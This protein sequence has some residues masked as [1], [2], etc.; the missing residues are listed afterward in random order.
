MIV[1]CILMKISS[2]FVSKSTVSQPE[3]CP[4]PGLTFSIVDAKVTSVE[5]TSVSRLTVSS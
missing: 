1:S 4:I 2:L 3:S 5:V